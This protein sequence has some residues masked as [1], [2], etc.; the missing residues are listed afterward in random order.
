MKSPWKAAFAF[1]NQLLTFGVL[2]LSLHSP[3]TRTVCRMLWPSVWP[4]V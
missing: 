3:S 1:R 4:N 2:L